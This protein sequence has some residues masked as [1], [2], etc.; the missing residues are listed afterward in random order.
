MDD[1]WKA[2]RIEAL[3]SYLPYNLKLKVGLQPH[4]I[5]ELTIES[6][7]NDTINIEWATK[8]HAYK[9]I[10]YPF[11]LAKE[12]EFDGRTFKPSLE[13]S[14]EF[15]DGSDYI[16]ALVLA[17]EKNVNLDDDEMQWL[18]NFMPKAI[19]DKLM[20]WHI[21]FYRLIPRE[22]AVTK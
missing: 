19:F 13:L 16:V 14:K 5:A 7:E 15:P 8:N 4:S 12:I 3:F 21:D 11:D 17:V 22:I 2:V 18:L 9:P 6:T 1:E 10:L 20:L